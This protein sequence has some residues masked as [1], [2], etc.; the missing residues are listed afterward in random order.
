MQI[1]HNSFAIEFCGIADA[2]FR[3]TVEYPTERLYVSLTEGMIIGSL[4]ACNLAVVPTGKTLEG[5][6]VVGTGT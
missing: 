5:R 6:R 4:V 2:V 3:Q 1:L